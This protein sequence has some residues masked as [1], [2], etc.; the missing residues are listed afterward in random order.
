MSPNRK[1]MRR[2]TVLEI[3][4][5]LVLIVAAAVTIGAVRRAAPETELGIGVDPAES[6]DDP[7]A[8]LVT[9]ERTLPEASTLP[10]DRED[11]KPVGRVT[12]TA[13]YECPDAFD[14]QVAVFI[15]EVVGDVLRRD[16]GAWV[17]MND[18]AYA[19]EVGPL[20]GH[21]EFRGANSGLTV[22][23]PERLVS[24]VERTGGPDARGDVL[25]LRGVVLRTDP[26]DGGGL[27]FRAIDGQRIADAQSVDDPVNWPQAI[28]AILVAIVAV[29][30]TLIERNVARKR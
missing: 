11:L 14:G 24:L 27:T 7:A 16:G 9:C 3:L 8:D 19:L 30:L 4:L 26:A 15:G 23:L 28:L 1:P 29:A 21:R 22:W 10:P 6:P 2:Q 13:I 5:A 18:D 12:S 17:L 20:Q 25:R